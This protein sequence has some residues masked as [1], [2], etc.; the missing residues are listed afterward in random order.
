LAIK[1]L[2]DRRYTRFMRS[3]SARAS[4][5][6]RARR[7]DALTPEA[8]LDLLQQ[9]AADGLSA[10]MD[11]HGVDRATAVTRIKATRRLGRR[12]SASADADAY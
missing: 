3:E 9:L 6:T 8:R 2:G 1:G 5:G 11:T 10:Y 4:D 12:P 7:I